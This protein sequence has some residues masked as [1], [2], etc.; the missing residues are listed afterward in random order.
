MTHLRRGVTHV[1]RGVNTLR[2]GGDTPRPGPTVPGPAPSIAERECDI[3]T[4]VLIDQVER[5][6]VCNVR[7]K[8]SLTNKDDCVDAGNL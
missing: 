3:A 8:G 7:G 4:G 5:V 1:R 2:H 6:V